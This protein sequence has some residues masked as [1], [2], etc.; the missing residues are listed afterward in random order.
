MEES[1][2]HETKRCRANSGS[3]NVHEKRWDLERKKRKIK[4]EWNKPVVKG[5]K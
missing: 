3:E 1:D 5:I 4:Q 2:D